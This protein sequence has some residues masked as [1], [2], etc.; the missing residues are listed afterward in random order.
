M[1][2]I[3]IITKPIDKTIKL[4]HHKKV[5]HCLTEHQY[6]VVSECRRDGMSCAGVKPS[7]LSR[8]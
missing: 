6:S 5:M 2:T 1:K 3:I 4:P 7:K 8:R